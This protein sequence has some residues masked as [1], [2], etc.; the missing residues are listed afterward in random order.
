MRISSYIASKDE[1]NFGPTISEQVEGGSH[2]TF[3]LIATDGHN[4]YMTRWPNGLPGHDDPE[5]VLRFPHGL[6]R[7]TESLE[8]CA[9]RLVKEQL[10]MSVKEVRIAYWDSYLDEHDH[11]HVEPGCIVFVSGKPKIPPQASEILSFTID[12]IPDMSFWSKED[13]LE[14]AKT[15]LSKGSKK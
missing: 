1:A 15:Q 2:I 14:L 8:E 5:N 11:W 4:F 12:D 9:S 3:E 7:R 10:G 13:F 6:I